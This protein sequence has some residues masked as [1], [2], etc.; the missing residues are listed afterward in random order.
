M[1]PITAFFR[2]PNG[3]V[4]A[5]RITNSAS[6]GLAPAVKRPNL[7]SNIVSKLVSSESDGSDV[8][9]DDGG[10][11][12]DIAKLECLPLQQEDKPFAQWIIRVRNAGGRIGFLC[13]CC[14]ES[15][16]PGIWTTK[17]CYPSNGRRLPIKRHGERS[18]S[19]RECAAAYFNDSVVMADMISHSHSVATL[20]LG[21]QMRIAEFIA[22]NKLPLELYP[23]MM[24][25]NVKLGLFGLDETGLYRGLD[26][27]KEMIE[28]LASATRAVMHA[29]WSHAS[30]IGVTIDETTDRSVK[31]QM[32]L[33]Y[34][35]YLDGILYEECAGIEQLPNGKAQ[36]VMA[37]LMHHLQKDG[38]CI[39]KVTFFGTD[40]AA[41]MVGSKKGV[42]K[43]ISQLNANVIGY[44]CALH[45]WSLVCKHAAADIPKL[46]YFFDNFEA[47]A[48]HFSFSAT[49]R[50]ELHN[51]QRNLDIKEQE[52]V[53]ACF[54]RWL[55]HDKLTE[56]LHESLS[57]VVLQLRDDVASDKADNVQAV[58]FLS[59][60]TAQDNLYYL[61]CVRD[62]VSQ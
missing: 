1:Q 30:E 51:H 49:R 13:R 54:T 15:Q 22:M 27:G 43:R 46:Q 45:R 50:W 12:D 17:P 25:L 37:A 47:L 3:S 55:T 56:A 5:S 4:S 48:R 18:R 6:P 29:R 58:G 39:T 24:D 32:I 11:D 33:F 28:S 36:T 31:S 57:A 26:A 42:H 61:M 16:P 60:L 14:R 20:N 9:N 21:K 38:I 2:S 7:G 62:I 35:Y 8:D 19:H 10:D 44:H 53:E 40:G 41:V 52:L 59:F 34:K 23:Q